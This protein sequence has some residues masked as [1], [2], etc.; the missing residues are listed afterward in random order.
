M[1]NKHPVK[2]S[3]RGKTSARQSFHS[4][5]DG[6]VLT[7]N[8]AGYWSPT[9]VSLPNMPSVMDGYMFMSQ[10]K[11]PIRIS[12]RGR[13]S[14]YTDLARLYDELVALSKRQTAG[15]E[16]LDFLDKIDDLDFLAKNR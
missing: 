3:S 2:I 14:R 10:D 1:S 11:C 15:Q 12:S 8:S 16:D 6:Y 9:Q 4:S 5:M 7:W 13:T